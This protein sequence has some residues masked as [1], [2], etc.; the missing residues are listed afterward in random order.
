MKEVCEFLKKAGTFYL[1]TVDGDQPRVRP[2]GAINEYNGRLYL[3]TSNKKDVY[4]QLKANP[5]CEICACLGGQWLRIEAELAEDDD[6]AARVAMLEA[7]PSLS[8]MYSPDD[9]KMTVLFL[10]NAVATLSSFTSA[11]I[12]SKF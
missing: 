9:G 12:V 10:K 5:K 2:F 11:P 3:I 8:S 6:R 4:A 1:A 7:Y